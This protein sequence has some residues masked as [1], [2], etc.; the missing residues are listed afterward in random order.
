MRE[1]P[2]QLFGF[3]AV[4]SPAPEEVRWRPAVDVYRTPY[5]W[6]LKLELAGVRLEDISI[7]QQGGRIT[8]SGVRRDWALEEGYHHYMMEISYSRF[9]RTIELPSDPGPAGMRVEYR[10][11]LLLIRVMR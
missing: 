7:C 8:V 2:Q 10:D 6:L 9:E 11:G 1:K 5:G 4:A 3:F